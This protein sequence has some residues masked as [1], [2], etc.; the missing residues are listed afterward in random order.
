MNITRD[1]PRE[2][3][4]HSRSIDFEGREP[5]AY[6]GYTH[7]GKLWIPTHAYAEWRHGQP[8]EQIS[9]NGNILKKDGT[10]G[11]NRGT[12]RYCTPA[13]QSW[14]TKYGHNAP[15]WLLELFA[16]SAHTTQEAGK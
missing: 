2:V 14:D 8:I 9:V 13:H 5:E 7:H 10:P 16:D 1:S 6:N 3:H 11:Q 4:T 12:Q 15:A